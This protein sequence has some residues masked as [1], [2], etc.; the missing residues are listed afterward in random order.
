[1]DEVPLAAEAHG[2]G[3]QWGGLPRDKHQVQGR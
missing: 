2:T 3:Y 1:M